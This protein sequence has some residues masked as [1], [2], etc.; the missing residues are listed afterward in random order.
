MGTNQREIFTKKFQKNNLSEFKSLVFDL[1]YIQD[2]STMGDDHKDSSF[3]EES[4]NEEENV[5]L[6]SDEELQEALAAGL[7]KPGL[8]TVL[9]PKESSKPKTNNV[10]GLRQKLA[11][12]KQDQPWIEK[13]DMS[14]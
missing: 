13:L 11:E 10:E 9:T 4:E 1:C 14:K 7:L 12:L 3:S 5:A 8:N 2:Y 6:D